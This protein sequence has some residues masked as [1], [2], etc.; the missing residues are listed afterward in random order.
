MTNES[1]Q[2][3]ESWDLKRAKTE[4]SKFCNL[5]YGC[6]VV[7]KTEVHSILFMEE[8]IVSLITF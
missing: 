3:T 2:G 1:L 6:F 7:G 8:K 5:I 4:A